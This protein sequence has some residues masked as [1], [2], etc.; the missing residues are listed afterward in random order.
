ML[1]S[2]LTDEIIAT[3]L[4]LNASD[5]HLDPM[6]DQW[7]LSYRVHGRVFRASEV[8]DLEDDVSRV[9]PQRLKVLAKLSLGEQRKAQDGH[10]RSSTRHGQCDL[11]ISTIPTIRGERMAIRLIPVDN[12]FLTLD[13][14]GLMRIDLA[15][16]RR[17]ASCKG[18]LIVVCGRAGSGKS[19]TL[20]AILQDQR[21]KG[22]TVISIED[23]V[24]RLID[25]YSQIE[26]DE[27]NGVSFSE[28]LRAT[29][30][31]DPEVVMIGEIRDELTAEIA[32]RA[33][34]TGHLI[35][36]SLHVE[37]PRS[38]VTRLLDLRLPLLSI[39]EVIRLIVHQELVPISCSS[40]R[41]N[42]CQTCS[43]TGVI[44]RKALFR[45]LFGNDL[46]SLLNQG[47]SQG[48]KDAQAFHKREEYEDVV[49]EKIA[50]SNTGNEY[51]D[52]FYGSP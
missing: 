30:R 33:G 14:L 44:G 7:R 34:L 29:L 32:L 26:V 39:R 11:R 45:L 6:D 50:E 8:S 3:G 10:W 21:V 42:G 41:G 27:R 40:C 28:A 1:V 25:G 48:A 22:R 20:H 17:M 49:A 18:G 47:G 38:V 9:V 5:I 24:E 36:T 19:T 23:P 16:I 46:L 35:G 37:H 51:G 31:Q 43:Q 13:D 15:V 4:F 2:D 52:T 12:P